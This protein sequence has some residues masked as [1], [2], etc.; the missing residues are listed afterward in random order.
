MGATGTS[1]QLWLWP[2]HLR[3]IKAILAKG[4][5]R[6]IGADRAVGC[7]INASYCGNTRST[8]EREAAVF[9]DNVSTVIAV[10]HTEL[11]FALAERLKQGPGRSCRTAATRSACGATSK[12]VVCHWAAFLTVEPGKSR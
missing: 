9:C 7:A 3:I 8:G 10:G 5:T 2:F 11:I 1:G 12:S 6:G 4:K